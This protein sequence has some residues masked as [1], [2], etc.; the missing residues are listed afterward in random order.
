MLDGH[1]PGE[2]GQGLDPRQHVVPVRDLLPDQVIRPEP[3]SVRERHQ[4]LREVHHVGGR[5]DAIHQPPHRLAASHPSHRGAQVI[6][7]R[8]EEVPRPHDEVLGQDPPDHLLPAQ[9]AAGVHGERAGGVQLVVGAGLGPVEH[10]VGGD[11]QEHRAQL[12]GGEGQVV[13]S[14][15]VRSVREARG[16]L[17]LVHVRHGG[18]VHDGLGLQVGEGLHDGPVIPDVQ[19]VVGEDVPVVL[20]RET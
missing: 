3:P 18:A 11:V 20:G 16:R 10:V 4:P 17:A 14:H 8:A 13:W 15:G 12:A 6:G 9:L 1:V 19:Q 7:A 2:A 5:A